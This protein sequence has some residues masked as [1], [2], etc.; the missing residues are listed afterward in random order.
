MV[1]KYPHTATITW[2]DPGTR[3]TVGVWT[4]GTTHTIGIVCDIQEASGQIATGD[5]GAVLNYRY[6]IY[7]DRFSGVS[8]VPE[9]A[10]LSFFS[11][12][13]IMVHLLDYQKHVEIKC[14][15]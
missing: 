11:S 14:Q 2:V 4:P 12:E 1:K 8:T 10:K 7:A 5:G 9:K 15:G 13:H 3:N 6:R